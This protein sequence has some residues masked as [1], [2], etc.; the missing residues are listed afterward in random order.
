VTRRSIRALAL[1][2]AGLAAA[3]AVVPD[4]AGQATRAWLLASL[5][6]VS[7]IIVSE[8]RRKY[9]PVSST[10]EPLTPAAGPRARPLGLERLERELTM[11]SLSSY[12][13]HL[14]LRP[15]V[16]SLAGASLAGQG[17]SLDRHPDRAREL[18]GPELWELI[19][20]DREFP[21]DRTARGID[22]EGLERV[23]AR[24]ERLR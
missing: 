18:V 1:P 17:V 16:R 22:A 9:R 2:T 21:R 8:A 6:I 14:R 3:L 15:L 20:P 23:I 4:A 7:A 11:A 13:T 19:R 12:D 10:V 24:L 5:A